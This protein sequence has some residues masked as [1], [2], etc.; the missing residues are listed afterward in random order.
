MRPRDA[1]PFGDEYPRFMRRGDELVKIGW[2][3]SDHA[4]YQHRAP[5]RAVDAVVAR[6][7]SLGVKNEPFSSDDLGTLKD[8]KTG[9]VF[10]IY[11]IFVALAWLR[12]LRLVQQ[13]GRKS[14]YTLRRDLSLD[15]E[16]AKAWNLLPAIGD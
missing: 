6:L 16:V 13:E 4:E 1:R 12:K 5:R 15:E 8:P 9:G 2:S 3:K 11:Q 7:N 10:P 14:G